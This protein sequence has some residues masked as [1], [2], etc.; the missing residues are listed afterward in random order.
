MVKIDRTVIINAPVE[1][2]FT[3]SVTAPLPART[4]WQPL[5]HWHRAS[6][7]WAAQI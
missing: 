7:N 5:I 1:K 6:A 4:L 2:V 3:C